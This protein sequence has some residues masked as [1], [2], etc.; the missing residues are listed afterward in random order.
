MKSEFKNKF[1]FFPVPRCASATILTHLGLIP[2]EVPYRQ[3]STTLP[4]DYHFKYTATF[5]RNPWERLLSA[6]AYYSLP[7]KEKEFNGKLSSNFKNFVM[8]LEKNKEPCFSSSDFAVEANPVIKCHHLRPQ[9]FIVNAP[10][11]FIGKVEYLQKDV[12]IMSRKIGL[13]PS[14]VKI[15]LRKTNHKNYASYYDT[16]TKKVV[17]KFYGADIDK[18]KYTF[19]S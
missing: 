15:N 8:M 2:S 11:D 4:K 5:V 3:I 14:D 7:G 13:N 18:F 16:I 9:S 12:K 6:Y 10:C 17:E 1:I 19:Q